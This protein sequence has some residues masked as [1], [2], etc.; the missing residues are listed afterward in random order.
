MDK[1]KVATSAA[2][3]YEP[4]TVQSAVDDILS[5]LGGI[6]KYVPKD[7]KVFVKVNLVRDMPP[8]KC[9]TTHPQVVIAL[10]NRL[11]AITQNIVVGDSSGGLYTK[12]AMGAVYAKCK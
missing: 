2:T 3:S 11:S 9:G 7:A 10:V 5:Q 8:E 12:A 1:I 6:E 4:Q